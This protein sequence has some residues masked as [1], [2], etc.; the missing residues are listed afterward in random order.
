MLNTYLSKVKARVYVL[1]DRIDE[2]VIKEEYDI[3]RLTL[4]GLIGCER[5][6]RPYH[7]LPVKLFLRHDLFQKAELEEFGADKVIYD[8]LQ[9]IWTPEDIRDFLSKRILYNY[10]R[11]FGFQQLGFTLNEENLYVDRQSNQLIR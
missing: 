6:Y 3:Q 7:H 8:T 10:F 1:I 2:F 11:V 9:L 4:Q 5:S